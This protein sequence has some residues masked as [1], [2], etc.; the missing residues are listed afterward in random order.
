MGA[1]IAEGTLQ[2]ATTMAKTT[3]TAIGSELGCAGYDF[4]TLFFTYTNGD[5]TGI[6]IQAHMLQATGGTE[7][8]DATWTAAA[9]TKTATL[10]ELKLI[11]TASH[12]ATYDVRGISF[13]KFTQGGSDND[14]TPTGTLA[15][16][17]TLFK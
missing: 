6:L 8:Q 15:A 4:I 13:I 5:E 9:G 10:N 3:Q 17:Y 7:Y 2:A 16:S 12:F 1:S 14:G 11:A